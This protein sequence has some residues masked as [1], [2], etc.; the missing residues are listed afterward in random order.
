MVYPQELVVY[1][2]YVLFQEMTTE[3]G[4]SFTRFYLW[5]IIPR[6]FIPL[7]PSNVHS[8]D[9]FSFCAVFT[10]MIFLISTLFFPL[11]RS[12]FYLKS[13]VPL[14]HLSLPKLTVSIENDLQPSIIKLSSR[15]HPQ[16]F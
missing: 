16:I 10:K 3:S 12:D 2:A 13:E 1:S 11:Q 5:F 4:V 6:S 7:S 8:P 15:F 9:S 14:G